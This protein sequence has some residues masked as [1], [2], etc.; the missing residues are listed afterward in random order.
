MRSRTRNSPSVCATPAGRRGGDEFP[1][2]VPARLSTGA[3]AIRGI[4]KEPGMV[5]PL[6]N[7]LND[8][9]IRALLRNATLVPEDL[10]VLGENV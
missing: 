9:L 3:G 2:G 7:T 5:E 1:V 6:G 4:V 8:N 10:Y